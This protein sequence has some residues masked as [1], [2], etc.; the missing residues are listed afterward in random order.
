MP[1]SK[2]DW[3]I[4]RLIGHGY[5]AHYVGG[6]VRDFYFNFPIKDIDITTS[7]TV[8]QIVEVFIDK[9]LDLSL[10]HFFIVSFIEQNHITMSSY[11][12]EGE[13]VKYR[14]PSKVF[15]T[16]DI[17]E[18][19]KRRDFTINAIYKNKFEMID[20]YHGHDHIIQKRLVMIGDP[21]LRLTQDALRIY[22]ALRFAAIY[23]L[24]IDHNLDLALKK[25]AH[26]TSHL[27]QHAIYSEFEK[28]KL[29]NDELMTQRYRLYLKHYQC[30]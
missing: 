29:R 14:Y 2:T 13:Y 28:V 3:I 8:D 27:H 20:P 9:Q 6:C 25:L 19:A 15:Y 23:D 1:F 7:A 11:R 4:Q 10:K 22:R 21:I 12:T 30:K 26:L 18:D 5:Q 24:T 16:T 17:F